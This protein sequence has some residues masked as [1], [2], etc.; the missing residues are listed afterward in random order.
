LKNADIFSLK[1]NTSNEWPKGLL[2]FQK[3][4]Y[5]NICILYNIISDV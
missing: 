5:K 3:N 1:L 2:F 4:W